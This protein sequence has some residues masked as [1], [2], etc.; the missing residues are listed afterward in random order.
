MR[1]R[2][3]AFATV[4]GLAASGCTTG[5]NVRT[6][7]DAAVNFGAF[8]TYGFVEQPGTDRGEYATLV[9]RALKATVAAEM[10][11][12][13]YHASENPDL[14]INFQGNSEDKQS[15]DGMIL[16]GDFRRGLGWGLG[17]HYGADYSCVRD[18]RDI[19][20]GTLNIDVVDRLK[21]ATVWEGSVVRELTS[22][23]KKNLVLSL[24]VL[25]SVV[26]Q[27]YPYV[28][29]QTAPVVPVKR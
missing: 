24:P 4:C 16:A 7:V 23:E 1:T 22:A 11:K 6:N 26:F 28:A 21:K 10:E 25:A 8:R 17:G 14:L 9:T 3:I 12:R 29:G 18:V 13:G 15:M 20:Q 2:L 19:T 27:A 5:P